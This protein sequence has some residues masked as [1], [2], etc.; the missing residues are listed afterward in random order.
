MSLWGLFSKS[1]PQQPQQ[2]QVYYSPYSWV[3]NCKAKTK[4]E[5]G[6]HQK[7]MVNNYL[8]MVSKDDE[9]RT[10]LLWHSVGSGKTCTALHLCNMLKKQNPKMRVIWTTKQPLVM[11]TERILNDPN[12][13]EYVCKGDLAKMPVYSYRQF[14]SRMGY[15]SFAP[16]SEFITTFGDPPSLE[17]TILVVDEAHNMYDQNEQRYQSEPVAAV[18]KFINDWVVPKN[19]NCYVILLTATPEKQPQIFNDFVISSQDK[20]YTNVS[21]VNARH[22]MSMFPV[23]NKLYLNIKCD[24][25]HIP[26]N[27]KKR[28]EKIAKECNK[29][30]ILKD[31]LR[32]FPDHKHAIITL[33]RNVQDIVNTLLTPENDTSRTDDFVLFK[34][35]N[36]CNRKNDASIS[37]M[38]YV[39]DSDIVLRDIPNKCSD[40]KSKQDCPSS[41]C[42]WDGLSC[43]YKYEPSSIT[44]NI[45]SRFADECATYNDDEKSCTD[46]WP[47]CGWD[48]TRNVCSLN[49]DIVSNTEW[50]SATQDQRK[51]YNSFETKSIRELFANKMDTF[52]NYFDMLDT[53]DDGRQYGQ[54]P[55]GI[56]SVYSNQPF[57]G[58][59]DNK[60]YGIRN[61]S[62]NQ[63]S[64]CHRQ[65][66][67]QAFNNTNAQRDLPKTIRS[68]SGGGSDN[69]YQSSNKVNIIIIDK[70]STEGLSLLG[71]K[72]LHV[73]DMPT[74]DTENEQIVGRIIRRCAH[75]DLSRSS[76]YGWNAYILYY[77][78][79]DTEDDF[80]QKQTCIPNNNDYAMS[81][82]KSQIQQNNPFSTIPNNI[83][84]Y[85]DNT[86]YCIRND[87]RNVSS[88]S[89]NDIISKA[90]DYNIF[91]T[92]NDGTQQ[93][94]SEDI[95]QLLR[96]GKYK[97]LSDFLKARIGVRSNVA[98]LKNLVYHEHDTKMTDDVLY[99][100]I[101]FLP[102]DKL[103]D[104]YKCDSE[105][106]ISFPHKHEQPFI[107]KETGKDGD[108]RR[109]PCGW[110]SNDKTCPQNLTYDH[111]QQMRENISADDGSIYANDLRS[112]M[113][114]DEN[115][116][117]VENCIPKVPSV[118]QWKTWL[119][120]M[121]R[122]DD[123]IQPMELLT[124][125]LRNS[126]STISPNNAS[127]YVQTVGT[128][129]LGNNEHTTKHIFVN[130]IENWN[131]A[132]CKQLAITNSEKRFF[133]MIHASRYRI[134]V[135]ESSNMSV[136]RYTPS[137]SDKRLYDLKKLIYFVR[138]YG[139]G[140]HNMIPKISYNPKYT[141]SSI[142]LFVDD[143]TMNHKQLS[144]IRATADKFKRIKENIFNAY[145][146][147]Y[148]KTGILL[149][150][151][152]F[153]YIYVSEDGN[154]IIFTNLIFWKKN[155]P[156]DDHFEKVNAQLDIQMKFRSA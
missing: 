8:N 139:K 35:S 102:R 14:S 48:K 125:V 24:V 79:V 152:D 99:A 50:D 63:Y 30:G 142:D 100:N 3:N 32:R 128:D 90:I 138:T 114:M 66:A 4:H 1:K 75:K 71:T 145:H 118:E 85:N 155:T 108:K 34:P 62:N 133:N 52:N 116:K 127:S 126:R 98:F 111:M 9:L 86:S 123:E 42:K 69:P 22:D 110:F 132:G 15:G 101:L 121:G 37:Q 36:S 153:Q 27:D 65:M 41:V 107:C 10:I 147:F 67:K 148:K 44:Q 11:E 25:S 74:T 95:A 33:S 84:A 143:F 17:N 104:R 18:K 146:T 46:N 112:M 49:N 105:N 68:R 40:L 6:D 13:A 97:K 54:R 21:Y 150:N 119:R 16:A 109:I 154:D 140:E 38:S 92:Y 76:K 26:D 130:C 5:I 89:Y 96:T 31:M 129:W 91:K 94:T 70:N 51:Q 53:A 88:K 60:R 141:S 81:Y 77:N 7:M 106:S 56:M 82:F 19:K 64:K 23:D 58:D 149:N 59:D 156:P 124:S 113:C 131:Y 87:N 151:V 136:L 134:L 47:K 122:S 39:G 103:D 72:F 29:L 61:R 43:T 45:K 144:Q 115:G 93:E 80:G 2:Q 78:N 135:D 55:Y 28:N 20:G 73:L 120:V 117:E 83:A 57:Q 12:S 137:S